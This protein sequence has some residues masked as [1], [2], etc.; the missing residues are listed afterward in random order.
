MKVQEFVDTDVETS[1][2]RL[3]DSPATSSNP[4][5]RNAA[6]VSHG[7]VEID[8]RVEQARQQMLELRRQQELLEKER[9]E[10]EELRKRQ[11]D[12]ENGKAEM[13]EELTKMITS[14]EQEEFELTKRTSLLGSFR[15]LYRDYVRQLNEI[16]E[17]EW[18]G[19]DIKAQLAKAVAVVEAARDEVNKGRAQLNLTKEGPMKLSTDL[20]SG[21]PVATRQIFDFQLEFQRGLARSLPLILTGLILALLFLFGHK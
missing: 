13:M 19:N 5:T 11:E 7:R 14:I 8:A 12:F 17:S 20:I 6:Q 9:Q 1:P 21:A 4:S 16:R 3:A 15:D 10:L 2:T 18:S